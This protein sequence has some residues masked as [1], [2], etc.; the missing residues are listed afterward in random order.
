LQRTQG[1]GILI[2]VW[3]RKIKAV[4]SGIDLSPQV[5]DA[6]EQ[7]VERC[8]DLLERLAK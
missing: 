3:V 6:F 7:S 4:R 5:M 1:W 8:R 2:P